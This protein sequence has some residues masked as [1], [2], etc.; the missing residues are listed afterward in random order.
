MLEWNGTKMIEIAS[1]QLGA[2]EKDE[3]TYVGASHAV[4]LS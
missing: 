3:T 1:V 4:W 2:G